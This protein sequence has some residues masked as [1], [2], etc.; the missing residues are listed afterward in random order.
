[1]SFIMTLCHIIVQKHKLRV[2]WRFYSHLE[3]QKRSGRCLTPERIGAH[4]W[5]WIWI[6]VCVWVAWVHKATLARRPFSDLLCAPI[7]FIPPVVPCSEKLQYVTLRNL[8]VVPWFHKNIY[9]SDG[10]WIQLKPHTRG[11][12]H[13]IT[14][15]KTMN[16]WRLCVTFFDEVSK[17]CSERTLLI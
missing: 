17:I 12:E 2:K 8:I 3:V 14:K 7:Y 4:N 10:I 9:L 11:W 5:V 15:S 13:I 6:W 16:R 1:M